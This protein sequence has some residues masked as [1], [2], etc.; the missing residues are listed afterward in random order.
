MFNFSQNYAVDRPILKCDYIRYTPPSLN[1]VN[2]EIN[3]FFIDNPRDGSAISLRG[4]YLKID[5]NVTHRAG[6]HARYIDDYHIGLVNISPI[7]LFN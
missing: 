4:S 1:L 5:F 2:G 7:A 3:D 6:A